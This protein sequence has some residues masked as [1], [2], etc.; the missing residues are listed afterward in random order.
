MRR[1]VELE[2]GALC[3]L[4]VGGG[5]CAGQ[6]HLERMR[7]GMERAYAAVVFL[8][9]GYVR[10]SNCRREMC[11]ALG[12]FRHVVP[13]LLPPAAVDPA[14]WER[15]RYPSRESMEAALRDSGWGGQ[16]PA[17]E[18]WWEHAAALCAEDGGTTPEG[19]VV[20]WAALAEFPPLDLRAAGPLATER[21]ALLRDRLLGDL[22]LTARLLARLSPADCFTEVRNAHRGWRNLRA[23]KN[24]RLLSAGRRSRSNLDL[25]QDAAAAASRTQGNGGDGGPGESV[26]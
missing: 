1:A 3:W 11:L 19:D 25:P 13:V 6:N 9:D 22:G 24:M 15:H 26:L 10:S 5:M 16:S 14:D 4:D 23:L 12:A 18:R 8:S 17:P 20:D 2:T 7:R 21:V